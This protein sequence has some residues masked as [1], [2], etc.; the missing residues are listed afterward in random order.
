MKRPN[1]V[2]SRSVMR[3]ASVLGTAV[4]A[5]ILLLV[6]FLILKCID[7]SGTL[8]TAPNY[9]VDSVTIFECEP[10][11][12]VE[13]LLTDEAKGVVTSAAF[14]TPSVPGTVSVLLTFSDGKTRTE[15][16]TIS[17]RSTNLCLEM[18]GDVSAAA[19]LGAA[20]QDATFGVDLLQ[21]RTPGTYPLPVT[22][23][24]KS[25]DFTVTVQD[26]FAPVA[27]AKN[28][29]S[30]CLGESPLPLDF[31]ESY[32]DGS[33]VTVTFVS[34][35]DTSVVGAKSAT[36][37]LVDAAGNQTLLDVPY[38]VTEDGD[39]PVI[40][41][42]EETIQTVKGVAISPLHGVTAEDKL[43]GQ[44]PV[45]ASMTADVIKALDAGTYTL[46]YSATDLTGNTAEKSI[47]LV[48]LPLD[49]DPESLTQNDIYRMGYAITESILDDTMSETKR[50]RTIYNY[51]QGHMFYKDNK[52]ERD[53]YHA[54]Y[55][56]IIRAYGDCR[57]YYAYARL[58]LDC[59]GFENMMVEH[60]PNSPTA[61]RHFWNLVVIDG[62]W[63]H[64]DTTPRV[65]QSN[66]FMW[67]DAQMNAYSKS[68][69]NCFARDESLY[70]ATP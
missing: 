50:A 32:T 43:D 17:I 5:L 31:V 24:G 37:S 26:S 68:H 15:I 41:G 61:S 60:T 48:V 35:P 39:A 2:R 40:S 53:W 70:P 1:H 23:H 36:I 8:G 16:A 14:Q 69:G 65:G 19:L 51:V 42:Y 12:D 13:A 11:P 25:Y 30:F 29:L 20:Y 66:F 57:N 46:T 7:R 10:M 62:D 28:A 58:L 4:C 3:M 67:T 56:A 21:Y 59:A 47:S 52:D 27:V 38:T 49:T 54:A 34:A 33:D 45:T 9:V 44:L 55:L 63:Y 18:G 6:L 64:F 22:I